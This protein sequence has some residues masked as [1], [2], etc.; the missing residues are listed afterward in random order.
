MVK[1]T[2]YC[3]VCSEPLSKSRRATAK[4]CSPKCKQQ[5]YYARKNAA[6]GTS[7]THTVPQNFSITEF[8][9]SNKFKDYA[10]RCAR[11]K[12]KYRR[13]SRKQISFLR[14]FINDNI[15]EFIGISTRRFGKTFL[16]AVGVLFLQIKTGGALKVTILSGSEE[17]ARNCYKFIRI[18]LEEFWDDLLVDHTTRSESK[19]VGN[20]YIKIL[21]ASEKSTRGKGAD[22]L[23]IDEF[24]QVDNSLIMSAL[25]QLADSAKPMLRYIGTPESYQSVVR[26]FWEENN[27]I[28][29]FHAN[30]KDVNHISWDYIK[31]M[32]N[33]MSKDEF[34]I[35]FEGLWR[36][37][38]GNV[39]DSSLIDN[40]KI[41]LI[42]FSTFD[43]YRIGVDVGKKHDTVITVIGKKNNIWYVIESFK[44]RS[45]KITD[46]PKYILEKSN[47]YHADVYLEYST[48][49]YAIFEMLEGKMNQRLIEAQFTNKKDLYVNSIA[50]LLEQNQL[51]IHNKHT[52]LLKSLY[53]L[54]YKGDKIAKVGDDYFDS[55]A[56]ALGYEDK[57]TESYV[58][59]GSNI[60]GESYY[61]I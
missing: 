38:S 24:C 25:A 43:E 41:N 22:I 57:Q 30:W 5:A 13:L 59:F 52:D 35:E 58:M 21:V 2:R 26:Q 6:E 11:Y 37:S 56:Y 47:Q 17:Q 3:E 27:E 15:T 40:S 14:H 42:P 8:L 28:V 1:Y 39:F 34:D 54:H 61:L 49:T 9:K 60:E 32:K 16:A 44:P 55:L 31:R 20:G 45:T 36:A 48:I 19:L 46:I 29:K 4:Y 50:G 53:E 23:I 10:Q 33:R 51:K 12:M 7:K 18:G